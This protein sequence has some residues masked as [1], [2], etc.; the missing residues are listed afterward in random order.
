MTAVDEV[1]QKTDILGVVSQY[2]KMVKA[3]KM[4]RGLCP[5]HSEK[6]GSFFVYPEQQT[7]HCFG[8]CA[9]GGD[10][11]SFVM[12]KEGLDFGEALRLLARRAGVILPESP[13]AAARGKEKDRLYEINQVT[14]EF[15]HGELAKPGPAEK[16]REY[17]KRR[18]LM[19]KTINDFELGFS[20]VSWEALK[21]HLTSI[22]YK[23]DELVK[24][25]VLVQ[26]DN[27]QSHDR[28]RGKLMFPVR[29][30]RGH[31]TGFG[32][33]VLDDSLPKYINSPQ[34][35]VFDK[36]SCLYGIHLAAPAV[37]K[38]STA[39]IVEGYMDVLIAHQYSFTNVIA[40]LGTA[41]TE[42]QINIVK[43][44]SK[45]LI[46]ALDPDAAGIEAIRKAEN[47][48]AMVIY[49]SVEGLRLLN[50]NVPTPHPSDVQVL[51]ERKRL[52]IGV[53]RSIPG[54]NIK[55][56]ILP[57]GKDPDEVIKENI[58]LWQ[59]L[60]KNSI[61]ILDYTFNM[62]IAT[63]DLNTAEGKSAAVEKLLP[64]I[65]EI[66]DPVQQPHYLQKLA[67]IV[68]VNG[69]VLQAELNK[70]KPDQ[71]AFIEKNVGTQ[72]KR[73]LLSNP[74]EEYCLALLIQHPELRV[75]CEAILTDYFEDSSNREI[76][77]ILLY[78]EE[79]ELKERLAP[80]IW[81]KIDQ[82]K[83]K[84]LPEDS[85][86]Q[87]FTACVLRLREK[88]LRNREVEKEAVLALEMESGGT[89][90]ELTKLREQGIEGS[91]ELKKVFDE[92]ARR[93]GK[94]YPEAK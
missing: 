74:V 7:W 8:A 2:V 19:D 75:K 39:I 83:A 78:Q 18:G 71:N 54:V 9:T 28:F 77:N 29:D 35:D 16:A 40:T 84:V 46:F 64:V 85:L 45:N 76:L 53:Y 87:K 91:S 38:Q 12:K 41:I 26:G 67:G 14:A 3:G 30:E 60:I 37:R 31:V 20:P 23:E 86:E 22:G 27:G 47:T 51:K 52:G 36:S 43:R 21:A 55:V 48:S 15:Y 61:P 89:T 4:Y 6:H 66:K 34:T 80:E 88:Y 63:L 49:Q 94:S 13:E 73:P 92:K 58:E 50:P 68:K 42:K 32:A 10:V 56:A 62:V 90:A 11:F 65:A 72:L 57:N 24:A 82:L 70:I 1:K 5:F 79:S 44:L 93:R 25:G 17:A 33:R 69:R 59:N 81:E